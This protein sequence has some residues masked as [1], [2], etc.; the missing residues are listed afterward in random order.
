MAALVM[1]VF[2]VFFRDDGDQT[3]VDDSPL[4]GQAPTA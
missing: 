1:I 2:A 4:Q 3:A